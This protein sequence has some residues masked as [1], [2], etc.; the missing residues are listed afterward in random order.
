MITSENLAEDVKRF[1]LRNN[2]INV[3]G[4]G[5]E[6]EISTKLALP[7]VIT[8]VMNNLA[9]LSEQTG[10]QQAVYNMANEASQLDVLNVENAQ[11]ELAL[12][13]ERGAELV[14]SVQKDRYFGTINSVVSTTGIQQNTVVDLINLVVPVTLGMLGKQVA[15]NQWGP[16]DLA[17]SLQTLSREMPPR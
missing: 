17:Q 1:I 4:V 7:R 14:K 9:E 11:P 10:G 13:P 3:N 8:L 6:Q 5:V 12:M 16:D 2:L 15:A